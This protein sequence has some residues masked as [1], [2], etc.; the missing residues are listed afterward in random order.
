MAAF[1][2]WAVNPYATY[3]YCS[4]DGHGEHGPGRIQPARIEAFSAE[5]EH[6]D[7]DVELAA[8]DEQRAIDV[9]LYDPVQQLPL[10]PQHVLRLVGRG[11]DELVVAAV[12]T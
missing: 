1:R 6:V 4:G 12:D 10:A 8:V 2:G 3:A 7:A 5:C 9:A 11:D